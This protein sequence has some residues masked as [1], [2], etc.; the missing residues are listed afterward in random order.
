MK[1][2]WAGATAAMHGSFPALAC[3]YLLLFGAFGTEAPFFPLFLQSRGRTAQEIAVILTMGTLVRLSVSPIVGALADTVGIRRMLGMAALAAAVIGSSY[4]VAWSFAAL[5]IVSMLHA[6]VLTSLNPLA[7]AVAVTASVR[8]GS[9]AYGWV[10][11]VGSGSFVL[12]TLLSGQIVASF[13][14]PSIIVVSSVLILMM[15]APLPFLPRSSRAA[16]SPLTGVLDL[17]KNASFRRVLLVGGLV[18]GSQ[19][20][21][22]TFAAIHWRASGVS[23]RVIGLLWSEAV[24]SE[25]AMFVVAGPVLLRRLNAKGC[26]TL[27]ALA[28]ILQ[29]GALALTARPILLAFAQPLHGFTFALTQLSCMAFIAAEIP[30]ERAGS[31]QALYGMLSLGAASALLTFVSGEVWGSLGAHGFWIMSA[32]CASAALLTRTLPK[33]HPVL[34]GLNRPDR[35]PGIADVQ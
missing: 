26:L 2:R 17:L 3:L 20:M 27:G 1:A 21:S 4:L 23:P 12:A 22:D 33:I 16:P 19:A 13:G 28:G 29:W 10:R 5:V 9:F 8:E 30:A 15:L 34:T 35:A 32:I 6:S 14:L 7:D 24:A 18:I 25:V 11:G 31:A